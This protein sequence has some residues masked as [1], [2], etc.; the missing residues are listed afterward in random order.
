M[1][2]LKTAGAMTPH[3]ADNKSRALQQQGILACVCELATRMPELNLLWKYQEHD[4]DIRLAGF[5]TPTP[6]NCG[7][8]THAP[9]RI[10]QDLA[11]F[12]ALTVKCNAA[13]IVHDA[14]ATDGVAIFCKLVKAY[15]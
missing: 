6:S 15:K 3:T 2:T 12:L 7:R 14:G 5:Y 8:S 9:T 13:V 4:F 1:D 10:H 11:T